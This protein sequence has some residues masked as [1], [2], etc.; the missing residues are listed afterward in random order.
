MMISSSR[1]YSQTICEGQ[2]VVPV[3]TFNQ[4]NTNPWV[5]VFEENFDGNSLDLSRWNY[6][7]R[8]RYCGPEQQY[9]TS[10]NNIEVSNGI[11]K[12]IAKKRD[13]LCKS[14]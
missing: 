11:L 10:G 14:C 8:I 13:S 5:L 9:Y 4:C 1:I 6:G 3:V 7:P 12:L 2:Q